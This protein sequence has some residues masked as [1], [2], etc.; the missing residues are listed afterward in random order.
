MLPVCRALIV[1]SLLA[2]V[3]SSRSFCA[4]QLVYFNELAGGPENGHEHLF[5]SNLNW[6]QDLL[7][8]LRAQNS[9]LVPRIKILVYSDSGYEASAFGIC[10]T[11]VSRFPFAT[12]NNE[13]C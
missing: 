9:C 4:H 11:S 3:G 7:I 2:T 12:I 1:A 10:G 8:L 6:G 5:H 13:G